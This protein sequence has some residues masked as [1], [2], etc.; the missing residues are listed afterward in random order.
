MGSNLYKFINNSA[1][2][3]SYILGHFI[4]KG[5]RVLANIW[6]VHNDPKVWHKP[7]DFNPN[8][9]LTSDGK[10]VLNET[11]AY[12]LNFQMWSEFE[13]AADK[14]PN[15]MELKYLRS[16]FKRY[17]TLEQMADYRLLYN[18]H[19]E[20]FQIYP[21]SDKFINQKVTTTSLPVVMAKILILGPPKSGKTTLALHVI[22]E[23]SSVK[24]NKNFIFFEL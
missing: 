13:C 5:T 1:T 12:D 3:D 6:A 7:Q 8:R 21:M 14:L 17:K 15:L 19:F 16:N 22:A 23:V 9:F 10:Q 4:P 20:H 18:I 24:Y 2:E 11:N